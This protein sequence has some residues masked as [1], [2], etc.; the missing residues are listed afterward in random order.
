MAYLLDANVFIAA[1]NLHY[2]LDFCP[3]FW[4]WLV[5]GHESERAFETHVE[6]TLLGASGWQRGANAEWDVER[7]L[8]KFMSLHPY[9][10]EQKTEVIVEHF[11]RS[12][13]H[14]L[15]GRAKPMVVTSSRLHAVRYKLAFAGYLEENGYTGIRPL[16]AF[17]GTV[18]DPE[19]GVE[20]TEP[21]MNTDAVTGKRIS[22]SA[23][24]ERFA[25]PDYQVLLVAN[26][27]QTGFDQPLLCAMYVDKRLD[28]VLFAYTSDETI[29]EI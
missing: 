17:S 21:G 22:E 2:G 16:V 1:N 23:L 6:E 29:S 15:G 14:R 3:A 24:P 25:S 26:K 19:T 20:Y 27:Y 18:R 4:D 12:V 8:A 28:G 11:R 9:N 5:A 10:I 13:L 7:A